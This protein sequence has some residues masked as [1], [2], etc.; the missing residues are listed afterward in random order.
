VEVSI[1]SASRRP[2]EPL[3]EVLSLHRD[4]EAAHRAAG[5]QVVYHEPGAMLRRYFETEI[6]VR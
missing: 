3:A 1:L 4:E 5:E 6:R 2:L